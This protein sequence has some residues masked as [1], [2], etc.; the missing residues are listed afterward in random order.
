MADAYNQLNLLSDLLDAA[1]KAG[2]EA[3]DAVVYNAASL[4]VSCRMGELEKLERAESNDLGLRVLIGKQQ[5]MVSSTDFDPSTLNE[6]VERCVAMAK[7]APEDPYCG[8]ADPDQIV[9]NPPVIDICDDTEPTNEAMVEAAKTAEDAARAVAGVTNTEGAETGWSQADIA[10]AA[11]NGFARSYSTSSHSLAASVLAG[12]GTAMERDYDYTSAVYYSDLEDPAEIGRNAGE[13]AVKR[14]NAQK[15]KTQQVPVIYDPRVSGGLVRHYA[16]GINGSSI[17]RGTSFLKDSM[18]EKIFSDGIN[19]ID[20]P[21][22]PRG[23]RSKPFD[24]E[25]LANKRSAIADNG[26]L[27]TW[28]LDLS[29]AR[30]LGLESTGHASRGTSSPPSPSLTN[31]YMEA[32][33]QTPAELM[34]DIEN[35]FYITELIGMGINM[36]TGD[37]SRGATGFWI[38]NGEITYPVSEMTIAGNL[39]DMFANLVPANDLKFRYGT[40]APTIRVDGLTVAGV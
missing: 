25:G 6:V 8:L 20:D 36:I 23:F 31:L 39:K 26:V 4:S 5:A 9:T 35:G 16:G 2:A 14:L 28:V 34:A 22:R 18:G 7:A 38:E 27:T 10:I 13:R 1:K 40:D 15:V 21:H 37:Y 33:S 32:G 3:A 24:A 11:T 17:T 29:A 12:E 19:I 30:Q